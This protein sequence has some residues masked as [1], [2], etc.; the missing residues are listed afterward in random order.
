MLV[1]GDHQDPGFKVTFLC[2]DQTGSLR[3]EGD[4]D[5]NKRLE[6]PEGLALVPKVAEKVRDLAL[7]LH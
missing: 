5:V 6:S 7:V 2:K 1:L 3:R 4:Q